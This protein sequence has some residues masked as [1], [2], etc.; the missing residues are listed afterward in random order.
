MWK[1]MMKWLVVTQFICIMLLCRSN[2][3]LKNDLRI[4]KSNWFVAEQTYKQY[5]RTPIVEFPKH[6]EK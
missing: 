1:T 6:Y 5:K 3:N 4:I 2:A